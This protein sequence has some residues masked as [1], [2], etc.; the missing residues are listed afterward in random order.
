MFSILTEFLRDEI[1][2][3][4]RAYTIVLVAIGHAILLQ[5]VYRTI[6]PAHSTIVAYSVEYPR[7][8]FYFGMYLNFFVIL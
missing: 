3:K 8:V 7:T 1:V 2:K 4:L 5:L 6:L